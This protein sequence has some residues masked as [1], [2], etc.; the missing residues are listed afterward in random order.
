[1]AGGCF[2]N[3]LMGNQRKSLRETIGSSDFSIDYIPLSEI[4]S[5]QR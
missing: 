2:K 1:M 4:I 3:G 5:L